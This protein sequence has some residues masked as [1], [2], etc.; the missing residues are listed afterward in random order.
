[1]SFQYVHG[2]QSR[3][4]TLWHAACSRGNKGANIRDRI[5][6]YPQFMF[7]LWRNLGGEMSYLT[8]VLALLLNIQTWANPP[9]ASYS[10]GDVRSNIRAGYDME[11]GGPTI[12]SLSGNT[13]GAG[14][15]ISIDHY[16]GIGY[17]LPGNWA[18]GVKQSFTQSIDE[19]PT[20]TKDPFVA[21]DP[22]T[23]IVNSSVV[24]SEKY[25]M[26]LLAY[27]RYYAPFSRATSAETNKLGRKDAGNG[28]VRFLISPS[29]TWLDGDLTLS[30]TSFLQYRLAS[31]S[32]A[33]RQSRNGSPHRDDLAFVFDPILSYSFTKEVSA[34]FEYAFDM[35][36]ST[37]G[38]WTKYKLQDYVLL[39]GNF[40]ATKKLLLNPYIA[41]APSRNEFQNASVG[42]NAYYKFL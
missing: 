31:N 6:S 14:T 27:L 2:D 22:Y 12:K 18:W 35:N 37:E 1:M 42:I 15:S 3:Y 11:L 32:K 26:N 30:L 16:F 24:K 39:G 36:H 41:S 9:A 17:K 4:K 10:I 8:F 19:V 34:Y 21:N 20:A 7:R 25:G 23:T 5:E 40:Q 29:K 13:A 28:R 38:K 33:A